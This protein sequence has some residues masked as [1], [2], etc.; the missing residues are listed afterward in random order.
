MELLCES[1]DAVTKDTMTFTDLK[2]FGL[3]I[4]N[5]YR[6]DLGNLLI[7]LKGLK[8]ESSQANCVVLIYFKFVHSMKFVKKN[9]VHLKAEIKNFLFNIMKKA[10][11]SSMK[12]IKKYGKRENVKH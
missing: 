2:K 12:W 9:P 8:Q 7:F 1:P 4:N 6:K 3:V 10:K 11:F 5:T